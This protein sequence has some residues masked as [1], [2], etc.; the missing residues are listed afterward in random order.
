MAAVVSLLLLGW[1]GCN[2]MQE[3]NSVPT[4]EVWLLES[5]ERMQGHSWTRYDD[6]RPLETIAIEKPCNLIIHLPNGKQLQMWSKATTF[7]QEQGI[8][9]SIAP[10]PLNELVEYQQAIDEAKSIIQKINPSEEEKLQFVEKMSKWEA[11]NPSPSG[12]MNFAD[13]IKIEEK[14]SV[15]IEIK[16]DSGG[17]GKWFVALDFTTY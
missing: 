17:S 2:K 16:A 8:I 7:S 11:K 5:V 12:F 14:S 4:V 9:K 13:L 3:T 6:G 1:S 10:L 15:F